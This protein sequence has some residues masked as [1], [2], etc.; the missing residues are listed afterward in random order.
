MKYSS[1]THNLSV[2]LLCT[3]HVAARLSI[4]TIRHLLPRGF[5]KDHRGQDNS[6]L[7]MVSRGSH[8]D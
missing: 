2:A 6:E 3:P 4:S 1:S 8:L 5:V 7:A